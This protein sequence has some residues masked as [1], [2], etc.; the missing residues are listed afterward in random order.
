MRRTREAMRYAEVDR[1]RA[2]RLAARLAEADALLGRCSREF[3]GAALACIK[4]KYDADSKVRAALGSVAAA[5]VVL[6]RLADEAQAEAQRPV[7][8]EVGP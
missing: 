7:K 5:R 1:Q 6:L 4:G 8:A 2:L 3:S